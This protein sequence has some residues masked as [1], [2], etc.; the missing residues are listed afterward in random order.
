MLISFTIVY[1]LMV[2]WEIIFELISKE[3]IFNNVM[4]GWVY[5]EWGILIFMN[6][7]F[8]SNFK[9]YKFICVLI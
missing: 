2:Y 9:S 6:G 3:N 7:N 1:K 5:G 4:C 8:G